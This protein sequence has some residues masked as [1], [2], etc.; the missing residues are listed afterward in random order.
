MSCNPG[1]I[2]LVHLQGALRHR[3]P[4]SS[5]FVNFQ[6]LTGCPCYYLRNHSGLTDRCPCDTAPMT[7]Q[8]LPQDCTL[9]DVVRQM[10]VL[11]TAPMTSQHLPQDCPLH[12]AVRWG[13]GGGGG[14]PCDT[15][16]MTG[17][18]LPQDCPLHVVRGIAVLV[19][20]P[21]TSQHLTQDCPLHDVVR[22]ETWPKDTTL[23][24]KLFGDPQALRRTAAFVRITGVSV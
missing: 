19:T 20:A 16:P 5:I 7:S 15:A 3:V 1:K 8:H 4:L 12:D 21:M 2:T 24:D 11:V 18:H 9:R 23:R 6:H 14:C 22:R 17:Q 10:A 13:G